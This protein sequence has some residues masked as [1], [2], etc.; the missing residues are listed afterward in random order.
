M[1]LP[2]SVTVVIYACW[3]TP[4]LCRALAANGGAA[5]CNLLGGDP[6]REGEQLNMVEGKKCTLILKLFSI[7]N[8][9]I[10]LC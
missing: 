2:L 4:K 3:H 5:D 9:F 10:T 6:A 7:F 1:I 8:V